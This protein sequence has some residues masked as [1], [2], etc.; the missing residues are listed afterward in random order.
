MEL[1]E[2]MELVE[3]HQSL[4]E[5]QYLSASNI[6]PGQRGQGHNQEWGEVDDVDYYDGRSGFRGSF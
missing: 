5:H 6:S 2:F 4:A 3:L 1:E